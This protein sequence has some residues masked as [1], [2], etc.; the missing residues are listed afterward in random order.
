MEYEKDEYGRWPRAPVDKA[1]SK[2]RKEV[3]VHQ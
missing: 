2:M 1:T 3:S